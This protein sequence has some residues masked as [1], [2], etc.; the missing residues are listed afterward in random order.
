M[1]HIFYSIAVVSIITLISGCGGSDKSNATADVQQ[2]T[3]SG[4]SQEVNRVL[5]TTIKSNQIEVYWQ[6]VP[7]AVAYHL[8]WGETPDNL[9][10]VEYLDATST[11]FTHTDITPNTLYY[12]RLVSLFQKKESQYSKV[13]AVKSGSTAQ[14]MQ[15]DAGL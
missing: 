14:V 1:K 2:V 12:Y 8:E 6:S 3:P 15:S 13:L 11:H 4:N 5:T 9:M 7:G 10:H